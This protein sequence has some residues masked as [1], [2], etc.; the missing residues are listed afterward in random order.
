MAG[1]HEAP[2]H[3]LRDG[4]AGGA[5]AAPDLSRDDRG[6]DGLLAPPV[7]GGDTGVEKECEQRAALLSEVLEEL[8]ILVVRGVPVEETIHCGSEHAD[9]GDATVVRRW[10]FEPVI[11]QGQRAGEEAQHGVRY[12]RC[13]PLG[14][15]E[16]LRAATDEVA[17]DTCLMGGVL[18]GTIGRPAV[19]DQGPG[20][21]RIEDHAGILIATAVHDAVD[22]DL[23]GDERP[24]PLQLTADFLQPVSSAATTGAVWSASTRVS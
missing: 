12:T 11:P 22:R 1:A 18:E 21:R 20:E 2:E 4:A 24:E 10:M 16:E 8:A 9:V 7:G 17:T 14:G 15:L 5:V 3:G 23:R 13:A 19:P 6:T